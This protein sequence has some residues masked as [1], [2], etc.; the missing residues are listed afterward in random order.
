M[1]AGESNG[2][3]PEEGVTK[4]WMGGSI[5]TQWAD[6]ASLLKPEPVGIRQGSEEVSGDLKKAEERV[7]ALGVGA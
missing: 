1:E 6:A 4:A 3:I 5:R 2:S 7:L